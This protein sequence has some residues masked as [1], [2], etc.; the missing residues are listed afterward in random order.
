MTTKMTRGGSITLAI[1][2]AAACV[3]YAEAASSAAEVVAPPRATVQ[4]LHGDANVT[5]DRDQ[6]PTKLAVRSL[7]DAW[8]TVTTNENGK[9]F[10]KWETGM[11]N[12]IGGSSSI[13]LAPRETDRGPVDAIE[14]T[15]GIL[16]V[17]RQSGKGAVT[18]YMV[19]TP[20]ASIEPADYDEPVDFIVEVHVPKTS[21]VT[22]VSGNVRVKNLTLNPPA[23]TVLS[24]CQTLYVDE[25]KPKL[26]ALASSSEDLRRLVDETT[27][28]GTI[29]ANLEVCP[30]NS[31]QQRAEE[32]RDSP[33]QRYAESS[34]SSNYDFEDWESRDVYPYDD[35]RVLP[36]EPGVGCV[37]ILPGV[38]RWIVPVGV[39]AGWRYD[40]SVMEVYCRHIVLDNM[41]Y[42]DQYYLED[43]RLRQRQFRDLVYLA[44]IS[45]NRRMLWDAQR[46]LAN[47]NIQE[48][49]TNRRLSGLEKHLGRLQQEQHKFARKLPSA[50][51]LF[52]AVSNSLNSPRNLKVVQNFR[53]KMKTDLGVQNQLAGMA[54][55]ELTDLRSQVA[56][57]R[58][59][60]KRLALRDELSKISKGVDQGKL[61]IPAKQPQIKQVVQRLTKEQDPKKIQNLQKQLGGL[62]KSDTPRTADILTQDNLASLKQGLDKFPNPQKRNDLQAQFVQLQQSVEQ[63]NHAVLTGDKIDHITAKAAQET[64]VAKRNGFIRQLQELEK[65]PA[66]GLAGRLHSLGQRQNLESQLSI[67]Q[68]QQKRAVLEK[69]LEDRR[70]KQPE[71]LR[72]RPARGQQ[73]EIV[74]KK[75]E[76]LPKKS[77]RQRL[78]QDQQQADQKHL[79]QKQKNAEQSHRQQ[80]D[81][82]LQRQKD[83]AE[84]TH[85]RQLQ[86]EQKH[87]QQK[88]KN[89][90]QSHRQQKDRQLQRQKDQA[91]QTHS[92][93]LQTEQ[94]HLQQQQKDAEQSHRQQKQ[95]DRER[96][97]QR[98]RHRDMQPGA[99][100][101]QQREQP[102]QHQQQQREQPKQ[103]QRPQQAPG[104]QQR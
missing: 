87:L 78:D 69:A 3:I 32:P 7:I 84:Q 50:A 5:V 80:K 28:P 26:E 70:K 71:L 67:E 85:S 64:D 20:G 61:P 55:K 98:A 35:I 37:V 52:Q 40:P 94:K 16:R 45:G 36:P 43:L 18:P 2:V 65:A 44:Q 51:N 81:R 14:M 33:G 23:E 30:V 73:A 92:R 100:V 29:V 54:G 11:L 39:F 68:D 10:L 47:V 102:K 17:T 46:Q 59:P 77:Q 91:E 103:H 95:Q 104:Q 12:S 75:R 13:F 99:G 62:T 22:V 8:N 24:S 38:G 88:Q 93:Q 79:Q 57:E 90:E 63:R 53:D 74:P 31:P 49:W 101:Q 58:N 21:V 34:P 86:T 25:G 27:I 96:Q 15:E 72:E 83:Q 89:A 9:L 97:Q 19:V 1:V 48:N 4:A 56:R 41:I 6:E 76:D 42:S 60:Q 82:Q 66:A